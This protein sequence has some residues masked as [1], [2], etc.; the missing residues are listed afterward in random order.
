MNL[1][2]RKKHVRRDEDANEIRVQGKK[3]FQ[4]NR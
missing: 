2:T 3:K 1:S 4:E